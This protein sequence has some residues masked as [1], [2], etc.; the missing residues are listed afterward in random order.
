M[1]KLTDEQQQYLDEL[2]DSDI[3]RDPRFPRGWWVLP[4]FACAV[5]FYV[6][7]GFVLF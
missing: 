1:T 6:T 2:E 7:L 4:M 5:I 3:G